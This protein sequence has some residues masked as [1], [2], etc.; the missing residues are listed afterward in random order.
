MTRLLIIFSF[1][2]MLHGSVAKIATAQFEGLLARVPNDANTLVLINADKLF[3]SP[4]ADR[5]RW[6]ARRKAAFDAGIS[7]LPP[8]ANAVVLA[9]R[10]DVEYF[11]SVWELT[12]VKFSAG[13]TVQ[14]VAT[15]FGGSI[16]SISQRAAARLPDDQY[17]V[18]V[19]PTVL[20]AYTP[21]NRQDVMRWLKSTDETSLTQSLSP[22]LKTAYQYAAE[23]GTPIVMA[24]D[25]AGVVSPADAAAKLKTFKSVGTNEAKVTALAA[26][27]GHVQ[28][29]TLGITVADKMTG[30]VRIDFDQSPQAVAGELKD[31]FLEVL[32]RNGA[33][34]DDFADWQASVSGNTYFLR[35]GLSSSGARRLLS[36][37]ELSHALSEAMDLAK[38]SS[39]TGSGGGNPT[40]IYFESITTMLDDLRD[41]PRK[42][43]VQTAGQAG[44]WYGKYAG[45]IDAL[46]I[47]DVD[48][49][50]LDL[51]AEISSSLRNAELSLRGVGMKSGM[52]IASGEASGG[53]YGYGYGYGG[54]RQSY[55]LHSG[56]DNAS[57]AKSA[58]R[59]QETISSVSD[60]R[61]MWANIDNALAKIRRDLTEKY[62]MEF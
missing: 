50:M 11:S 32:Q 9:G 59:K 20:G 27:A 40:K 55:N 38:S 12:L 37:L 16:D 21:A 51:G 6:D 45:K 35:G 24:I 41:K 61:Q 25:V 8:D 36:V 53:D 26:L 30:A 48:T 29:V 56:M 43:G 17:V 14:A 49:A 44:T 7:M 46:P 28:G 15:R 52:R 31:V 39:P 33:V 54:Y 3:G 42:D 47:L 22:Y 13:R 23:V 2:A 58:I 18:Q 34:V 62:S 4:V 19:S 10:M 5:E 1:C 57:G 60:I